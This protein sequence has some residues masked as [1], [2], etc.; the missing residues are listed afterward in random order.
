MSRNTVATVIFLVQVMVLMNLGLCEEKEQVELKLSIFPKNVA[1]GDTCYVLIT[2]SNHSEKI[3]QVKSPVLT[4]YPHSGGVGVHDMLRFG[5]SRNEKTWQG[6]FEKAFGQLDYSTDIYTVGGPTIVIPGDGRN[7]AFL[8]VPV[9]FPPLE[10]FLWS[11]DNFWKE[12]LNELKDNPDGLPF[13]FWIDFMRPFFR[14]QIS[15]NAGSAGFRGEGFVGG[16]GGVRDPRTRLTDEVVVKFRNDKEMKLIDRWLRDT[17]EEFFPRSGSYRNAE[18]VYKFRTDKVS[19]KLI[20]GHSPWMFMTMGNRYPADP[21]AP[22]TWQRWKELEESITPSTM[23]DEIRLT[24]IMIQ[25]CDTKDDAVLKEL[26][27]W[28][29]GMNDVQRTVMAKSLRDRAITCL[30]TE[31]L[32]TPFRDIYK[33]IREYDVVPLSQSRSKCLKDLGLIE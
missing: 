19:G 23:R 32:L 16:E 25:Y 1:I 21:N 9:Q 12:T 22:E 10:C 29:D 8:A 6:A 24:R 28:F 26:K 4:R 30:G 5:L 33:T 3:V 14:E 20:L 2:A 17:P 18:Y 15:S 13:E 7:Y 27:E 31:D 11:K